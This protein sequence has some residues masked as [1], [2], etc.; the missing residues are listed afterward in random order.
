MQYLKLMIFCWRYQFPV[1]C[2]IAKISHLKTQFYQE[3]NWNVFFYYH[4]AFFTERGCEQEM[5]LFWNLKQNCVFLRKVCFRLLS[6]VWPQL[7][8]F[9][10]KSSHVSTYYNKKLFS[11]DF[12]LKVYTF[13]K[14]FCSCGVLHIFYVILQKS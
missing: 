12:I 14:H 2:F 13:C 1:F 3:Y 5:I 9:F 4:H 6:A 10:N 7:Y 8:I 11:K